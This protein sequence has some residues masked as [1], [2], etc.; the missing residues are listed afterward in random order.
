MRLLPI[1]AT[2]LWTLSTTLESYDNDKIL[3]L[4]FKSSGIHISGQH[5]HFSLPS[6]DRVVHVS[7]HSSLIP[8]AIPWKKIMVKFGFF[9]VHPGFKSFTGYHIVALSRDWRSSFTRDR[10]CVD[11]VS[12]SFFCWPLWN[13]N[14]FSLALREWI[15]HTCH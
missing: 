11:R 2:S 14:T 15:F 6:M 9:E 12:F 7:F 5:M 8:W 3:T 10:R 4:S 1:W 13:I